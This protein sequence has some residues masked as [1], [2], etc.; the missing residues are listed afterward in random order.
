MDCCGVVSYTLNCRLLLNVVFLKCITRPLTS[1]RGRCVKCLMKAQLRLAPAMWFN[2]LQG[3][4]SFEI[5]GWV[6]SVSLHQLLI[7][8]HIT[9][10]A[11]I[12]ARW[13]ET[14]L[15]L[16]SH[17]HHRW[18]LGKFIG[19]CCGRGVCDMRDLILQML[20]LPTYLHRVAEADET[21]MLHD[22]ILVC[23]QCLH[24]TYRAMVEKVNS[25]MTIRTCMRD[26]R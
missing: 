25:I 11:N 23:G 13:D 15:L 17:I 6:I 7:K 20:S 1:D 4:A 24:E 5:Y 19:L 14:P 9:S 10:S 21:S 2:N 16:L 26:G 8:G 3:L 18:R 22:S 12:D